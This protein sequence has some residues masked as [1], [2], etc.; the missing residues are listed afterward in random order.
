IQDQSKRMNLVIENVLQ[1]SRRRQAEP[2][3][4][5][6]KEWLQRF[7]DEYP[8]R[9]R[10]D[11]QLHLQ[12]G[13]GDSQTRREPNHLNQVLSTLV[14]NGLSYSATAHGRG[15]VWLSLARD[16][17]RDPPMLKVIDDAPGVPAHKL[18]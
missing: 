9:L 15:P 10:N 13:A 7:V 5:D 2:Q 11:S 12:L 14:Q 4:L 16:T 8:G 17:Q 6:L 3:Q 18:N 1:L